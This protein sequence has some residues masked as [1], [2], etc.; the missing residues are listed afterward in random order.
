MMEWYHTL[1]ILFGL[2]VLVLMMGVPVAFAFMLINIAGL[3]V[4]FGG[5][6]GLALLTPSAS[7]SV[8]NFNL[9][10]LPMF[11]LMGELLTRSGLAALSID[12]VDKWVGR[13]PGR[14]SVVAV[15]G[16]TFFAALSGSAMASTAMLSSTL[17][18]EMERRGYKPQMSIAPILG[19]ASLDPLIPPSALAILLGV[20]ANVSIAKLLIA[21]AAPGFILAGMF[22][23]YFIARAWLQPWLAPSYASQMAS[24][25]ERV[26]SLRHL[27]PLIGLMFIVLGLIF[28]G[29][30]TPTETA[31]LGA[32]GA[33]VLAAANRRLSRDVLW[34]SAKATIA[35]T[36]MVLMIFV[37]SKAYS[38]MLAATGASQGFV[39]WVLNL[40]LEPI[41]L[42]ASMIGIII[43]LGC[44]ID[45]IS[46]MLL[47]V[48][49]F[50]PVVSQLQFDALWF[51][52]L[53]LI[54]LELGG[55]T[56]PFGLQLFV[57]KA[58]QPHLAM[59]I[60]FG[61]VW[62]IVIMQLLCIILFM[63]VPELTYVPIQF[64]R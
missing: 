4:I 21:G 40:P 62:P 17:M 61:S 24:R 27:L 8:A 63:A 36:S 14:L 32:V 50:M 6:N 46:I 48:P 54:G 25:R 49:L 9:T 5:I 2:L 47:T 11:I 64:M 12:A 29:V 10:P 57:M 44:F 33:A 26:V 35:T 53:M 59:G 58:A 23:V 38:Q 1:L 3:L 15:G 56:P 28:L 39:N 34:Q 51:T 19:A 41:L 20:L 18:P 43:L 55:I 7:E 31:A 37:G 42:V 45:A 16:G 13:V 52:L 22:M 60:I 30:A